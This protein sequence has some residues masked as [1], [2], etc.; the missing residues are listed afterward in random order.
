MAG[1]VLI[2]GTGYEIT[3][4]KTLVGGTAYDITA[5]KTLVGGTAYD[6]VF[7][8]TFEE[9]F[10]TVDHVLGI[11]RSATSSSAFSVGASSVISAEGD[12]TWYTFYCVGGSI[13]IAEIVVQNSTLS[14]LTD[15]VTLSVSGVTNIPKLTI[16]GTDSVASTVNIYAGVILFIHF[17][18]TF[19][20]STISR[21]FTKGQT[22]ILKYYLSTT[23]SATTSRRDDT[24]YAANSLAS[25]QG[26]IM[27]VFASTSTSPTYYY[28]IATCDNPLTSINPYSSSIRLYQ[29]TYSGTSY[30]YPSS[31]GT[32]I[33]GTKSYSLLNFSDPQ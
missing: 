25:H 3:A 13:H 33:Y 16:S 29:Y 5:G 2:G 19:S 8:P 12:T 14:S 21:L 17:N 30:Y 22:N 10:S 15:L 31:N 28:H 27:P 20:P 6:I 24:R 23:T 11:G 4:G 18:N 32:S 26:V 1:N 9:V 7:L